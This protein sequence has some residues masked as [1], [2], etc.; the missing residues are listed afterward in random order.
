MRIDEKCTDRDI[1]TTPTQIAQPWNERH[2]RAK[3]KGAPDLLVSI[4]NSASTTSGVLAANPHRPVFSPYK[5]RSLPVHKNT[6]TI[7][8]GA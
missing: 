1:A 3:Y 2:I 4:D 6:R 7:P 8:A 5:Q